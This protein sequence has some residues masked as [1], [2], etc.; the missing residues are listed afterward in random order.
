MSFQED[1]F[2]KFEMKKKFQ[3]GETDGNNVHGK[4]EK[5]LK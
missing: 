5:T 1:G 4:A 3:I 2:S